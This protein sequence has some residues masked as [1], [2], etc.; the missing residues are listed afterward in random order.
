[1]KIEYFCKI[2][3][4]YKRIFVLIISILTI[5]LFTQLSFGV[6]DGML[7]RR[8]NTDDTCGGPNSACHNLKVHN[9]TNT[10][11]SKWGG[12][13]GVAGGK[14]GQFMCKTCHVP[15][16]TK[17]IYLIRETI[18][19]PDG[20]NW[21]SSG[22]SSV[23]VDFRYK[24]GTPGSAPY[25]MGDDTGGHSTSTRICEV[26]HSQNKYHNYDTANNTG[27]LDHNNA[28]DCTACHP[29]SD[30][31]KPGESGGGSNCS[32]CHANLYNPMTGT[33]NYH[34][35]INNADATYPTISQPV[36]M[37]GT[38]DT[39]RRCLMCH[40][41]HDIFR[42]DI[43]TTNGGRGK[44]LRADIST[45]PNVSDTTTYTNTDFLNDATKNGGICL[46]CHISQQS[47]SYTQPDG[48]S[49]TPVIPYPDTTANKVAAFNS[50]T[51]QY[52]VSST[53]G[54]GLTNTFNA[55]CVK[56]HN[57]T[58]TKTKQT[59]TNKF[60][61]H[62]STIRRILA[63][64]GISSPTD[65]LEE[66]FCFRC[67]AR[68][69]D[70]AVTDKTVANKDWYGV[71]SMSRVAELIYSVFNTYTTY[72][73]DIT[74]TSGKHKPV[75]E[76]VSQND[77]SLSGANR[78][79]ECADC[80]NPHSARPVGINSGTV[81]GYSS[82]T[83]DILTD[84][85]KSWTVNQW[86]GYT[87]KIVDG[88]GAGEESVIYRNTA[89]TLSVEFATTLDTT[90]KYIIYNRGFYTGST[91]A[92][93]DGNRVTRPQIGVWGL[94]PTWPTQ[95]TP[96]NWNDKNGTST[97][98]EITTQFNSITT[99]NRTENATIQGQICIKCHSAYAY[100]TN[101]PNTPSGLP[102]STQ[103]VWDNNVGGSVTQ[104]DKANEFNPNNLGYHP[105]FA[106][107]KNQ[108]ITPTGD[109]NGTASYYNP[110]WPKFT[111]GNITV[112]AGS[113]IATFSSSIPIT[114]IPGWYVYIGS[115]NPSQGA[116]KNWFQ[117][118]SIISDTQVTITP[119][120][121]NSRSN[122]S[123]MLTAGLGNN[124]VPPWGPWSTMR[125]SD[126]H[127]SDTTTDPMGPHGSATKYMLKKG[128]SQRFLFW[129]GSSVT[130]I[131]YTPDTYNSCL[132][133]HRRDVYGDFNYWNH[134]Y[135]L[136]PRQEHPIDKGKNHSF[137]K[138]PKWGIVCMNC[139]GGARIGGIHGLNMGKGNNGSAGSYSGKRLLAGSSWYAVTRSSTSQAGSCWTKG[140]TDAVDNCAHTHSNDQFLSGNN[141]KANYDYDTNP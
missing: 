48:T 62:D 80:H 35:Y 9:S 24:S 108:P 57:D 96:P 51:H 1:M 31:F 49:T 72:R 47:K 69:T 2:Q 92:S 100:G 19:T 133:C 32:T 84:N 129:N 81:T 71:Q 114:V 27:G 13:W 8:S 112:S 113:N 125:C 17:N 95:P 65:P 78:H 89:N 99:W 64:L 102:T 74:G 25:A 15:H 55:N 110:N 10:A 121:T 5:L 60:G 124:F 39:N 46:S 67:H 68:T 75:F 53:F 77:G 94:D 127:S 70:T 83:P 23:S 76:G 138:R 123:F 50:S 26:C 3:D 34:H 117:I 21:A 111:T 115:N 88:T 20:S 37:G 36:S 41:D 93:S 118:T 42:P 58:L 120:P 79:V 30:A 141:G 128:I 45:T 44:N 139:H 103:D 130:T 29:H 4:L 87:V 107:G 105:I 109:T 82:G 61:L 104:G 140:S 12:S 16:G 122:V 116:T 52:T 56:C 136:Y 137:K 132:N 131:N 85:T 38:T 97:G 98:E 119:T 134:T 54:G 126:C 33:S 11:S 7:L 6:G 66:K 101:P 91:G 43:N 90:S 106:L 59:S 63:P 86:A 18:T 73:H 40:V 135:K 14:Y 22:T 28:A